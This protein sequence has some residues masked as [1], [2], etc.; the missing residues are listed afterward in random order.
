M[1]AA[2]APTAASFHRAPPDLE[3]SLDPAD[4]RVGVQFTVEPSALTSCQAE[5][6]YAGVSD[7]DPKT[8][9]LVSIVESGE[10][11]W[12]FQSIRLFPGASVGGVWAGAGVVQEGQAVH[13]PV[14]EG[15]WSLA[16][17][18]F[19]TIQEPT[20]LTFAGENVTRVDLAVSCDEPITVRDRA[21]SQ[22]AELYSEVGDVDHG[23]LATGAALFGGAV[24]A[25]D[26]GSDLPATSSPTWHFAGTAYIGG[27]LAVSFDTPDGTATHDLAPDQAPVTTTAPAGAHDQ[28]FDGLV[29]RT[30]APPFF[31]G[32]IVE[33]EP[34]AALEDVTS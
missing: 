16:D 20:T 12:S 29:T 19:F 7:G 18:V 5:W 10:E 28:A 15:P 31:A 32:A 17:D 14:L 3:A 27:D 4:G 2:L 11:V 34:V 6:T 30:G 26:A 23:N 24:R 33:L 21:G 8:T 1:L 22:T 25:Q 13:V 9:G